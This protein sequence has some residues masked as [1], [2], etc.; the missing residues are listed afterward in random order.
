MNSF[1][2]NLLKPFDSPKANGFLESVTTHVRSIM[3]W[4]PLLKRKLSSGQAAGCRCPTR[5]P[6]RGRRPPGAVLGHVV[7]FEKVAG[8][9]VTL[10]LVMRAVYSAIDTFME[11]SQETEKI[12]R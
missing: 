4:W 10:Y 12:I 7:C 2:P 3:Y 8:T 6:L 11:S 9:R 5:H 1:V